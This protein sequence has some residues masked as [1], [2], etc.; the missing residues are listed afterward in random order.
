ME[1]GT[2]ALGHR[3]AVAANEAS[4]N[5]R[6]DGSDFNPNCDNNRWAGNAFVKVNQPCVLGS[7]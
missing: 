5:V 7:R 3:R 1:H 4:G 2:G 6:H